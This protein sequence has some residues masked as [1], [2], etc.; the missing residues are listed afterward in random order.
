L[1]SELIF[2]EATRICKDVIS[3]QYEL[4]RLRQPPNH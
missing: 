2:H 3:E 1:R 4:W